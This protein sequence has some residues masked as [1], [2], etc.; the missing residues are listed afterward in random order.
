MTEGTELQHFLY[1]TR[2][3]TIGQQDGKTYV[4]SLTF[5]VLYSRLRFPVTQIAINSS[6]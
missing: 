4:V 2:V 1:L 3:Y 5:N 6:R